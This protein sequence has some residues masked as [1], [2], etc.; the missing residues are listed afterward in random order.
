VTK[1][2]ADTLLIS[3]NTSSSNQVLGVFT[4]SGAII[5]SSPYQ[6][7]NLETDASLVALGQDCPSNSCGFQVSGH[8]NTWNNIGGQIQN[9]EFVCDLTTANTFYDQRFTQWRD[10][11]FAP[12]WFPSTQTGGSY[13]PQFP[14]KTSTQQRAS[15]SW[16][17][18]Q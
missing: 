1:D 9:N 17:P 16:I 7:Q 5:L 18:A 6:D 11:G 12:P 13:L 4:A 15:W 8:I 10:I 3:R 14:Q 2:T